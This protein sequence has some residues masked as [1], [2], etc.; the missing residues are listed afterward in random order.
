MEQL[1]DKTLQCV[2]TIGNIRTTKLKH[3]IES[4]KSSL[5]TKENELLTH[6]AWINIKNTG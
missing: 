3:R 6:E 1:K 2:G 5:W 4:T